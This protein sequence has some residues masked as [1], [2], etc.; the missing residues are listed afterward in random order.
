[1]GNTLAWLD[2]VLEFDFGSE[3]DLL[4]MLTSFEV[5]IS[6]CEKTAD[7]AHYPEGSWRR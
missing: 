2:E 7:E 1:M 4:D 3:K 5:A 6:E